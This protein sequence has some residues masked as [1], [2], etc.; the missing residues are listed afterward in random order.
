M[1]YCYNICQE[2]EEDYDNGD[3]SDKCKKFGRSRFDTVTSIKYRTNFYPQ[4]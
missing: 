4:K 1:I 3:F 2:Y